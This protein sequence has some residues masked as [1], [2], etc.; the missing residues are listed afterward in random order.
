MNS[1]IFKPT[2][3][4]PYH[5]SSLFPQITACKTIRD[6]HQVHA[7]F[8]KTRQIHDPLA[9]AEILRLKKQSLVSALQINKRQRTR[10]YRSV[11]VVF[12]AQ[13]NLLKVVQTVWKVGRDGI[14]AGTN[15]V[16][17]SVPR[18]IARVSVTVVALALSL[19][20]VCF[21]FSSPARTV[22]R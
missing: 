2:T 15:L 13:S 11:P 14:E 5:P 8:I 16:P 12:A 20:V 17:D 18:S 19:F 4:P 3:P 10:R 22:D 1:T 6:L 7:L 9:A 21:Y